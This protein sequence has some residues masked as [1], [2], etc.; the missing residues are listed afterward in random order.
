[1][2]EGTNKERKR[3]AYQIEP[4]HLVEGIMQRGHIMPWELL[5]I[6]SWKSAKGVAW[7]S[8]N[9]EAIIKEVTSE[10]IEVLNSWP[11]PQNVLLSDMG[12]HHW[13][14]WQETA[15]EAIGSDTR[16][17]SDGVA[18]GL[19]RLDGVGYPVATAILG[20]LKPEVFPVMDKWAVETIFGVGSSKK[21]W[22]R[23]AVY[24]VYAERLV[25]PDC[26]ALEEIPTLRARDQ[27]AMNAA[28]KPSVY[29]DLVD[30]YK[31]IP[32]PSTKPKAK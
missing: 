20:V 31:P 22:Q 21:Q 9:S 5:R 8:L 28:M 14:I 32:F 6:V 29:A 12:S 4:T 2:T 17:S 18:K 23:S 16:H 10:T 3:P 11:G 19:L 25:K 26:R 13:D 15:A 1:M 7:L 24:R 30:G 27:A